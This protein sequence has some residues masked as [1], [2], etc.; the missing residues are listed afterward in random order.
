MGQ[1]KNYS[2]T[3]AFAYLAE[4]SNEKPLQTEEILAVAR[5][6]PSRN[7][8]LDIGAGVGDISF[9]VAKE[10]EKSV[11]IEPGTKTFR[12][13][14]GRAKKYTELD[15]RMIKTNWNDFYKRHQDEYLGKFDLITQVHV[16]YFLRPIK[17]KLEEMRELL[18]P[19]G[20]LVVICAKGEDQEDDFVHLFRHKLLG[21]AMVKKADFAGIKEMFPGKVTSKDVTYN[22]RM[23]RFDL[24][25][26]DHLSPE[27]E[28]TNYFLQFTIKKWF[29]EL[30][31][32]DKKQLTSFLKKYQ[33]GEYYNVPTRQRV[34]VI[35]K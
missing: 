30:T 16:A 3:K 17:E 9:D 26:K 2:T 19:E 33:D 1:G 4:V 10:F 25:E 29:D 22:F 6:L 11:F 35:S 24:M 28:A 12:I 18:S 20:K 8:Y 5:T 31:P 23:R 15:L 21:D 13:M 7:L 32:K 27:N 14:R 34:Y